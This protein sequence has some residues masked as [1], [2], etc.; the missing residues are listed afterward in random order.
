MDKIYGIELKMNKRNN[1]PDEYIVHF[2]QLRNRKAINK[3]N[4][5]LNSDNLIDKK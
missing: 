2:L 4:R 3:L 1:Y 5:Y